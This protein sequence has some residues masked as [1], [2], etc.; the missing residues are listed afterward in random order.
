MADNLI[1]MRYLEME[2][3]MLRA[4]G[5]LKKRLTDFERTMRQI[6]ISPYGIKVGK[7]L[8]QLRGILNGTLYLAKPE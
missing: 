8:T 3:Q 6:E 2:G 4:I 1:F 5:V 7:P